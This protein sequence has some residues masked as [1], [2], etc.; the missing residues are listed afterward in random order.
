MRK[1]SSFKWARVEYSSVILLLFTRS[2]IFLF[3]DLTGTVPAWGL[4]YDNE[5]TLYD[6]YT[7]WGQVRLR[8]I[9]LSGYSTQAGDNILLTYDGNQKKAVSSQ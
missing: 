7:G 2:A 8:S 3:S 4:I 5:N 6:M 9:I 1:I